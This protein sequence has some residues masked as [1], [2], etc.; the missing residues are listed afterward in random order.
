[1]VSLPIL[2]MFRAYANDRDDVDLAKL[3]YGS[4]LRHLDPVKPTWFDFK[5]DVV[6][7]SLDTCS[8]FERELLVGFEWA[9]H[10]LDTASLNTA[11]PEE[12]VGKLAEIRSFGD[13][14]STPDT[15]PKRGLR[16][17]TLACLRLEINDVFE[18]LCRDH[19]SN[20]EIHDDDTPI[21]EDRLSQRTDNICN[22]RWY[23]CE[24][25]LHESDANNYDHT[26]HRA[27][28]PRKSI[29]LLLADKAE[30][31]RDL[32]M[33]GCD[34]HKRY[35]LTLV[36]S[37]RSRIPADRFTKPSRSRHRRCA[38]ALRGL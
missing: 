9:A 13:G 12:F 3:D 33:L 34:P 8:T 23:H 16:N 30:S 5:D 22:S 26:Q 21:D 24:D 4:K 38:R 36:C 10:Y 27:C 17:N 31:L 20:A 25:P 11:S 29:V 2:L 1:M 7:I 35:A 37:D 15:N 32:K 18:P 19:C 14:L 6:I 28:Q